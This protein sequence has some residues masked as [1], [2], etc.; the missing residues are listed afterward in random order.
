MTSVRLELKRKEA[1][2]RQAVWA[3]LTATE[4]LADLY[5]RLGKGIG[6]KRQ[7]AMIAK[8]IDSG[9]AKAGRS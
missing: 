8:R 7:R 9:T 4:Q 5:R 3:E 6:A 2:E 1:L